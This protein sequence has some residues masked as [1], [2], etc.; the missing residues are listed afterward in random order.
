[1]I[2]LHCLHDALAGIN[3]QVDEAPAVVDVLERD[4]ALELA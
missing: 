4:M 2:S 1:M 3:V